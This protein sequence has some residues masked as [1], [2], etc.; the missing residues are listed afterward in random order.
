MNSANALLNSPNEYYLKKEM[1]LT[2]KF[3]CNYQNHAYKS[4]AFDL[5]GICV[6]KNPSTLR[7]ST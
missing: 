7:Y 4:N 2:A 1:T 3:A 6:M 5:A